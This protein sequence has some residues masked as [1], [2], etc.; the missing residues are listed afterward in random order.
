MC[1]LTL[2]QTGPGD[3]L[4]LA[5]A[6]AGLPVEDIG[7]PGRRFFE[8]ADG[9]GLVVGYSG[10]EGCG[11]DYLLRSVVILPQFRS[12]GFGRQLAALTIGETPPAAGLYLATTTASGF[13]ETLG[14]RAVGRDDV[15]EEVRA[16]RQLSG[17]CPASATI[18]KLDRSRG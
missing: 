5:L 1:Q 18:M 4:K 14:F 2:R 6:D 9:D 8:C 12:R 10:L 16:T 11:Q 17:I 3:E 7:E 15:P 13:F